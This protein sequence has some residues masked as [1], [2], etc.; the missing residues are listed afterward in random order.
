MYHEMTRD[1]VGVGIVQTG[2]MDRN[3]R[4]GTRVKC[5]NI[6]QPNRG[7]IRIPVQRLQ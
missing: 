7:Q 4:A 5:R 2:D 3:A 6:R 1:A